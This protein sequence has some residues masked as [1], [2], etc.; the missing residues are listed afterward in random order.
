M[1]TEEEIS[2]LMKQYISYSEQIKKLEKEQEYIKAL[3]KSFLAK[4]NK[5]QIILDGSIA[6]VS[7][8]ERKDLDKIKVQQIL[9]PE[10]YTDCLK[11]SEIKMLKIMS[12]ETYDNIKKMLKNKGEQ[13]A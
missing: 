8:F 1:A 10:Q 6:I 12:Q 2:R 13:D 9:T 4:D 7:V 11:T 3:V 5:K